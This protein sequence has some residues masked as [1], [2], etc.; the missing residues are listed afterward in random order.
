MC[1]KYFNL[2]NEIASVYQGAPLYNILRVLE[3][4]A[5]NLEKAYQFFYKAATLN[6]LN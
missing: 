4:Y 1:K 6:P 3:Y 2:I 5:N